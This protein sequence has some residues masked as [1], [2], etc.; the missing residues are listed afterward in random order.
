MGASRCD[1]DPGLR[2]SRSSPSA[3]H[4]APSPS[5]VALGRLLTS[6]CFRLAFCKTKRSLGLWE[7]SEETVRGRCR[8]PL[9]PQS[10]WKHEGWCLGFSRL[11]SHQ[12]EGLLILET[13]T[14]IKGDG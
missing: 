1:L 6:L 9:C 14:I 10:I 13:G 12:E 2:V 7:G 3:Y 11:I 8:H 4:T 5:C